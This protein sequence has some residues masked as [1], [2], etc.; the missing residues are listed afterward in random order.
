V[1]NF[2]GGGHRRPAAYV[3]ALI[4]LDPYAAA[5]AAH[6][7]ATDTSPVALATHPGID[8]RT[9]PSNDKL[10]RVEQIKRFTILP[11][12]R[13]PAETRSRPP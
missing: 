9:R 1:R 13:N 8:M 5:F 3:V 4:V 11:P 7:G 12:S 6:H 10:S 2:R